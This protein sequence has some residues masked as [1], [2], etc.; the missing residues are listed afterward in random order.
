MTED[1]IQQQKKK[2][3]TKTTHS[4]L[5]YTGKT[6]VDYEGCLQH[7]HDEVSRLESS[8]PKGFK[9]GVFVDGVLTSPGV[10]CHNGSIIEIKVCNTED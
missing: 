9:F 3:N 4:I 2:Q 10:P 8:T 7:F 5:E 1:N 6:E